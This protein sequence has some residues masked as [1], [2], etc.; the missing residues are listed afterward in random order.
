MMRCKICGCTEQ[1]PCNPP[2]AWDTPGVCTTC[3]TAAEALADWL[4]EAVRPKKAALWREAEEI[5]KV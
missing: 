3:A 5:A 1:D 4:R 2:C